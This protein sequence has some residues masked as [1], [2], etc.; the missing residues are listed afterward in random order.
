M[1]P[2]RAKDRRRTLELVV[3]DHVVTRSARVFFRPANVVALDGARAGGVAAGPE[4]P[5]TLLEVG[6][7]ITSPSNELL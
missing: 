1:S 4:I 5:F 6:R 7:V 3:T 2:C